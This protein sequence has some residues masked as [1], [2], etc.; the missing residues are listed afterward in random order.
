MSKSLLILIFL[1]SSCTPTFK[2]LL[3]IKNPKVENSQSINSYLDHLDCPLNH[4]Y[5]IQCDSDSLRIFKTIM[6]CLEN[7]PTV[8]FN[9]KKY[10]YNGISNCPQTI[11]AS[12]KDF[13]NNLIP[14]S[15]D[16]SRMTDLMNTYN[17]LT[18]QHTKVFDP[19]K[20]YIFVY[21]STFHNSSKENQKYFEWINTNFGQYSDS[22]VII[23]VNVDLNEE[24]NLEKGQRLEIKFKRNGNKSIDMVFGKMPYNRQSQLTD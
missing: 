2:A 17:S 3:S 22:F 1:M 12:I 9:N 7:K 15:N 19:Q 21:W 20:K 24:W 8:Y 5:T 16:T 23:M 11:M 6:K 10:C 18:K 14:C 4:G 13:D